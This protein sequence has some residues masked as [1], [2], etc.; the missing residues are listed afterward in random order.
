MRRFL[1]IT[2]IIAAAALYIFTRSEAAIFLLLASVL[3]PI[4]ALLLAAFS[5][6]RISVVLK[7]PLDIQKNRPV[8]CILVV[9]NR[10]FVPVAQAVMKFTVRNSFVNSEDQLQLACCVEPRGDSEVELVFESACCGQVVFACRE[11]RV[12]DFLGLYG[13]RKDVSVYEKRLISPEAFQLQ[14][15]LAEGDAPGEGSEV[16][17]SSRKGDNMSEPLQIREYA[18]GDHLKQIHWKLTQKLGRYMVAEPSLELNRALLM[19][20]AGEAVPEGVS[21]QV[22]DAL[23]EAFV[24]VC[25]ALAEDSIPFDI[26]WRSGKSDGIVIQNVGTVDDIYDIMAYI[27]SVDTKS[28]ETAWPVQ[29]SSE[30]HYPLVAYFAYHVQ[31]KLLAATAPEKVTAFICT[32]KAGEI[33]DTAH[34]CWL[35]SPENYKTVLQRISI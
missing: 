30:L 24:S 14:V 13:I 7:L 6:G 22:P 21:P 18:E 11:M 15:T 23:A 19:C 5:A 35:F 25:L 34:A 33:D 20:W 32:G 4:T 17:S 9:K 8:R 29:E 3:L 16:L 10:S 1:C 2:F 27:L 26:A 31:R 12:Y 28:G